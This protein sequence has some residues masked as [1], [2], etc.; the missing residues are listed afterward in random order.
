M[1]SSAAFAT[2]RHVRS[3][4]RALAVAVLA[5]SLLAACKKEEKYTPPP[6]YPSIIASTT[7]L[8]TAEKGSVQ[9]F[10]V[11]LGMPPTAG[12]VVVG[13]SPLDTSEG[14]ISKYSGDTYGYSYTQYLT[15]TPANWNT[16][17]TIY[18]IPK[19]DTTN[20]GNITYNVQ[21]SIYSYADA[22]Y[23]DVPAV[24]VAVTNADDDVPGFTV[25]KTSASTSETGTY[26]TFTVVLN[27]APSTTV[28]VPVK[29]L[30]V[31]EGKLVVGSST[32]CTYAA[33]TQYLTFYYYSGSWNYAQ[34]V[35][36][37]PVD[38]LQDDNNVTYNVQVGAPTGDTNYATLTAKTVSVQN[39]DNDTAGITVTAI[40]PPL[41]TSENGGT[42]QFT[43]KLNTDPG[44]AT[45]TVPVKTSSVA[46]G[47]VT[48]GGSSNQET[49]NLTF[50]TGN[51]DTAQTV[52]V[53]GQNE[54]SSPTSTDDAYTVTVGPPSGDTA[55]AAVASQSVS[56]TNIDN[57]TAK[58]TL[59][60]VAGSTLTV[61]E[62]GTTTT[63]FQVRLNKQPSSTNSVTIPV[64]AGD[65][66]EALVQ[67]GNSPASALQTITLTFTQTDWQTAQTVTVIGQPDSTVDGN[68]TTTITVGPTTSGDTSYN[69]LASQTLSV[70]TVDTDTA[71]F[72]VSPTSVSYNEGNTTPQEISI[73]LTKKPASN[74]YIQVV[75]SNTAEAVLSATSGG[76][77]GTSATL[78]FTPTDALTAQK[79]YVKGPIDSIDDGSQTATITATPSSSSDAKWA[80]LAAKTVTA[81]CY[82][83][84]TA[85]LIV[86]PTSALATT[87]A[88]GTATFTVKLASKPTQTVTVP[89]SVPSAS[90]AEVLVSSGGG[91]AATGTTLYFTGSDWSTAQTVTV[92]GQNDTALDGNRSFTVNVGSTTSGD[93][94]YNNRT[95]TVTGTN[96]DNETGTSE[97]TSTPVVLN[98][99]SAHSGQVGA[100]SSSYYTY[101]NDG[102]AR[103]L[104]VSLTNA[105]AAVTVTADDDGNYSAGNLGSTSIAAFSSGSVY[106]SVAANATIFIRVST[107][108]TSGAGYT[109]AL[110]SSFVYTSGDVPKTIS[111]SYTYTYSNLTVSGGP[112]SISKVRVTLNVAHTY[113]YYLGLYLVSPSGTEITLS[114]Y[115]GSSGDNY[116]NT[117]FDDAASTYISSG[118]APFT[119]TF[120]P[121]EALSYL[122]GQTA[123]GTWQLKA[124]NYYSSYYGSIDSWSLEI[125]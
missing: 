117:V 3:T 9:S 43:V 112:T 97:G 79:V 121:E 14:Y 91:T 2:P 88:G 26:D 65:I 15:F 25:N 38:D 82:D 76:T 52:T 113:D 35:K 90:Q 78:T 13:V 95:A 48:G 84:D 115:N 59:T 56:L 8:S 119:G 61:N 109:L 122:N 104:Y 75:S 98:L 85:G 44:S 46:E 60:P 125:W 74:V 51:Y 105:T 111:G 69:A 49:V 107:A 16:P 94:N 5:A 37:C 62:T 73:V 58:F 100:S 7:A 67:G 106:V 102:T 64:T 36:I 116:T 45:I 108:S 68:Q 89:I 87:E 34:T 27:T 19:D 30:D 12:N 23:A 22:Y 63:S 42:A 71:G 41:V 1:S 10:T 21:L 32:S 54:V 4:S 99:T 123:N 17:Q 24:D 86:T 114:D 53:T 81:Y 77:Y 20:D 96:A 57:D 28:T 103:T 47:L 80:A 101:V 31:T 118:S 55:Y 40:N 124:Y 83:V 39:S 11:Q 93:G 92:H 70:T 29:S 18:V 110:A 120:K 66:T 6:M 72:T 33:E 50:N